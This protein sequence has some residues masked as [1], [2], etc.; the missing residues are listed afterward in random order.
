MDNLVK[1]IAPIPRRFNARFQVKSIGY[2]PQKN[3]LVDH[4]FNS[5]NFSFILS[6][7]GTFSVNK[8]SWS[9]EAPCVITQ[10]PGIH[11]TYGPENTWEELYFIYDSADGKI[12]ENNSFYNPSKPIWYIKNSTGIREKTQE[13][14]AL[15]NN[16]YG[17]SVADRLDSLCESMIMNSIINE[18]PPPLSENEAII[19]RIRA[20]VRKNFLEYHDFDDLAAKNGISPSSFRRHWKYHVGLSPAKYLIRLR[21]REACR[22]LVETNKSIGQIATMLNFDDPL[23]FSRKFHKEAGITATEYRAKNQPEEVA[24]RKYARV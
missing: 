16:I 23:Y 11:Y 6:G 20:Y 21:I 5:C 3:D 13:V 9:V 8:R 17:E 7:H 4:C 18:A 1:H 10:W 14:L 22:L 2:V 12:F 15:M 24:S 19:R